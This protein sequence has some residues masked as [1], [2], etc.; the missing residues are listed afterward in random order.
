MKKNRIEKISHIS[1][2]DPYEFSCAMK[3]TIETMQEQKLSCELQYS[4]INKDDETIY[5]VLIIGRK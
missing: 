1:H 3:G 2:T 5:T 4:I